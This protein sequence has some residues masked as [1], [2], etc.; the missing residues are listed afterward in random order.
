MYQE[1]DDEVKL[2]AKKAWEYMKQ[3]PKRFVKSEI[4]K[5]YEYAKKAHE[6]VLRLSGEPYISHPVAATHILLGIKPDIATIQACFL[7]DVI[8][9][10]E[11]NYEDIEA[12]FWR[13]VATLCSGMENSLWMRRKINWKSEEDVCRYGRWSTCY[14]YK[15]CW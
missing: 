10:T 3:H 15:A 14:F 2:I 5:A 4:K 9:D 11:I 6:W 13:E 12:E 1:I 8:E 7:H